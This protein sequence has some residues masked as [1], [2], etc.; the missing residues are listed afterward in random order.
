MVVNFRKG[1]LLIIVIA[2]LVVSG[3]FI[4]KNLEP[5]TPVDEQPVM[6][7]VDTA[8]TSQPGDSSQ[9]SDEFFAEYRME[10][11]RMRGKEVEML[12]EILNQSGSDKEARQAAS[13]RLV[14]IS[15]DMEREM[16][17]ENLIKSK[18]YQDCVVL[19]Q[20]ESTTVVV[21]ADHLQ[22]DQEKEI[23]ALVSRV[24]KT[25]EDQIVIITRDAQKSG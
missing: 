6:N 12:R 11:E 10:R 9:S 14:E 2:F 25:R 15:T 24:T 7:T 4:L 17:A 21:A 16:K 18:G 20:P 3:G 23:T 5:D 1:G 13:M 19:I 22:L 8:V